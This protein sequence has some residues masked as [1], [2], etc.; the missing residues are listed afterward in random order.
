VPNANLTP[1]LFGNE[2]VFPAGFI[3]QPDFLTDEEE[4]DLVHSIKD[5]Q[6]REFEFHG[7]NGKRRVV[8]FGWR[9]EFNGGGL[10]KTDDI[11]QLLKVFRARAESFA[12]ILPGALQ[13]V[14]ITEYSPGAAIG[15]HKDRPVFGDV[16]GISLLSPCNFRLRLKKGNRWLRSNLQV[17]PRSIYLL[18]GPARSEWEHSIPGA[19]QLR[20]SITFRNVIENQNAGREN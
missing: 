7:F 16:V 3:Y 10:T 11:P 14:L 8:S 6:F 12:N 5:L 17:E 18:R 19:K 13:Q 15:W 1:D 2:V 9:Y 20:Y 4:Q